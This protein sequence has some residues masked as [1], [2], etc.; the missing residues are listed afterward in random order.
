MTEKQL[1]LG[2]KALEDEDLLDDEAMDVV[3]SALQKT[4]R[5]GMTEAAMYFALKLAEQSW[6][7]CWRRLSIIADEDVGQPEVITAVDV[8]YRKFMA[9]KSRDKPAKGKE[10]S[11]NAELCV[12]CAAKILADAPKDRRADEFLELMDAMEKYGDKFG[13]KTLK[14]SFALAPDE[15]FDVHTRQGRRM[16][17]GALYW[18]EVSSETVNK[19]PA[20][21]K[22][23]SWF[24]PLMIELA[25][26]EKVKKNES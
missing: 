26:A 22:W 16:G 20:Y 7:S 11:W 19:T 21:E 17:R 9:M 5:R 1:D 3:K 23:R 12:V 14:D 15:A 13:L 8:L 25:K 6:Y 10:L 4:I 24:K 18:Y 2:G